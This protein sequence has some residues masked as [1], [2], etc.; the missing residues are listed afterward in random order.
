MRLTTKSLLLI[1][2]AMSVA[3]VL[4]A[5]PALSTAPENARVYFIT[6]LDGEVLTS[7]VTIRFGLSG[8]GVAPAGVM[9]NNTGH[10]HLLIDMQELPALN[11]SLPANQQI[12]HFGAGQTETVIDL[13]AGEHSLQLLL[14]DH[15]HRPHT[16]PVMSEKI[17]I[18]VSGEKP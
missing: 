2:A 9:K 13:P 3:P 15:L 14:G 18:T 10:H 6:P 12:K 1:T 8:M 4:H 17:T 11:Q 7:P 16:P 5:Q